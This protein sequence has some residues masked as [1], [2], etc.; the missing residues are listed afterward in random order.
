MAAGTIVLPPPT[1]RASC[2]LPSTKW[3]RSDTSGQAPST[4]SLRCTSALARS[5]IT[6]TADLGDQPYDGHWSM[7]H[8]R[9]QPVPT[10]SYRGTKGSSATHGV[11][12]QQ[13]ES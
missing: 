11:S 8:H 4:S 7:F 2:A 9:P 13:V 1:A 10:T 12:P 5:Y 6:L 3:C